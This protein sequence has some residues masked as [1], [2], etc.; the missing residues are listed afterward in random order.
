MD[1]RIPQLGESAIDSVAR[2]EKLLTS[3]SIIETTD[4]IK[5][6]AAQRGIDKKAPFHRPRNGMD[7]SILIEA[8]AECLRTEAG[9]GTRFAFVTRNVK[10][11][12][13]PD[14]DDRTPHPDLATFFSKIKSLYFVR[15]RNVIQRIASRDLLT[16]L[17]FEFG[18]EFMEE[19]RSLTEILQAEDELTLKIW[20]DRHQLRK[21]M[22]EDGKIKIVD[23]EN[24]PGSSKTIRRD[25]WEGA[26]RS[27]RKVE[28]R[29]GKNN[30]GPYDKFEWGML[31]GKL[32]AIRW[33]LGM[34]WDVLDT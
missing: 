25:I 23:K 20:Y 11:F 17:M 30:L 33:V 8:Y 24:Q 12:S 31:S 6:R 18:D 7:D 14:G 27:A 28:R 5:L 32:S 26:L 3:G 4:D 15:L 21:Q 9:R 34:D 13:A 19:A 22:I 1:H 2:I 29:L 10:D 16:E